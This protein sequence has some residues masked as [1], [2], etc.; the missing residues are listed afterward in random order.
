MDRLRE[1]AGGRRDEANGQR[2]WWR[3]RSV[4][5]FVWLDD[6]GALVRFHLSYEALGKQ[7]AFVW[8]A[9]QRSAE[10]LDVR[11]GESDPQ[12]NRAPLLDARA[13]L[14]VE[15]GAALLDGLKLAATDLPAAWGPQL[16]AYIAQAVSGNE[17]AEQPQQ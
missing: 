4:D 9:G 1:I 7:R 8:R 17:G 10:H 11:G 2:Q 16:V 14:R 3:N 13:A 5:L 15:Q 12:H 6:A